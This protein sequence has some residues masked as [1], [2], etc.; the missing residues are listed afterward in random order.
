MEYLGAIYVVDDLDFER[1]Q[2][3]ELVIR[4]TDSVSGVSAEVPVSVAVQDVNDCLPEFETDSYN[5]TVSEG[6]SFGTPIL[7]VVAHDNDTGVNQLVT[8]TIQTDSKNTS[9]HFQIDPVEGF[10]YLKKSLDHEQLNAHHFTV[11]ASDKGTPSLSS[12]AHVW[13]KGQLQFSFIIRLN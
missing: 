2:H 7:K 12:V 5:V 4:A 11:I 9:E 8:Y 10:V 6:A 13:V 1:K 3:Y